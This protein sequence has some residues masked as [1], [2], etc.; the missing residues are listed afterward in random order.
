MT[1]AVS[2][3][4]IGQ[5]LLEYSSFSTT[6]VNPSGAEGGIFWEKSLNSKAADDLALYIARPTRVMALA[7]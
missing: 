6:S 3:N 2:G 5:V 4:S 1:S 7:M